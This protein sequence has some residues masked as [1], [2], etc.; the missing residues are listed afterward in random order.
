MNAGKRAD[1]GIY[2]F[3]GNISSHILHALP[4][5]KELGGTFVVLSGKAKREVEKYGVPVIAIDDKPSKLTRFGFRF[6]PIYHYLS[7]DK[8]L[9]RTVDYLNKNA[10]VVLF[11]ELYDFD[12]SIRLTKPKTVFLTHGNMLK[13]YMANAGRLEL[14][15][16]YDYMA[17]LGPIVKKQFIEHGGMNPAQLVDLGVAR[18]DEL[19]ELRKDKALRS[20]VTWELG[21]NPR[22]KIV[23]YL[24]TFWGVSSIYNTGKELLRNINDSYTVLFR[25]H[26]QVPAKIRQEYQA[27]VSSRENI[28]WADERLHPSLTLP[29]V[30]CAS[31]VILGDVSS[32]V[33]EAILVEKPLIFVYDVGEHRQSP[34]DYKFIRE[35][36]D[37]SEHIDMDN[38]ADT[39]K[40]L[41]EALE[42]GIDH[43]IWQAT[44][45]QTFYHHDGSS[46]EAIAEF[47]RKQ[48]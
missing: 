16:Q 41:A 12:E 7:I 38:V 45:D 46:V 27:I 22:K 15:K 31:D 14:I 36:V 40:I 17:A 10:K 33:L 26:P 42:K 20:K 18:T 24:P 13:D 21:V 6:K 35:V 19:Y 48:L 44:K 25:L 4:L 32:V 47:V 43:K 30:L 28:F 2:Y 37:W 34:D 1:N 23:A 5:H 29:A 39:N 9:K 11:Y 8:D 3:L